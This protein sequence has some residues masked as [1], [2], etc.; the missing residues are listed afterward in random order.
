MMYLG[1]FGF[2][3]EGA[4]RSIFTPH[5]S[6]YAVGTPKAD[7]APISISLQFSGSS[8]GRGTPCIILIVG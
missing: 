3:F 1:T 8:S 7:V 4:N 5:A 6:S 2:S